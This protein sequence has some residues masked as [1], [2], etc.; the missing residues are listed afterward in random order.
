MKKAGTDW[1]KWLELQE[2]PSE[3][4]FSETKKQGVP[5]FDGDKPQ[6]IANRIQTYGAT[7]V[8]KQLLYVNIVLTAIS[9]F[10]A[11]YTFLQK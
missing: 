7:K 5:I 8:N 2:S 4:I 3:A 9:F 11:I 10:S 1:I 6:D